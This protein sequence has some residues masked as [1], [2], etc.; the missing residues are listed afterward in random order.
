M[1]K[2][3][4]KQ[5]NVHKCDSGGSSWARRD[6]V[7]VG[8]TPKVGSHCLMREKKQRANWYTKNG[9]WQMMFSA[10]EKTVYFNSCRM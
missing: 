2:K 4:E 6:S 7:V 5:K 10:P 3:G 1:Q 8:D 9:A